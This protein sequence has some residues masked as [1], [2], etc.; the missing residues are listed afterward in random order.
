MQ[1]TGDGRTLRERMSGQQWRNGERGGSLVEFAMVL[2]LMLSVVF[3]I[4]DFGR[5]FQAWIMLT[6]SAREG[7]RVA[8]T[9]ATTSAICSRVQATS[10]L[11]GA[12]CTVSNPGGVSGTSVIVT[13]QYTIRFI[14]PIGSLVSMLGAGRLA[15][16]Y[17]LTS[18]ADMRLE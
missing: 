14:T 7:A 9:G 15:S 12:T 1:T 16:S 11:S 17:T 8:A 2:P 6:N 13:S 18:T 5:T 3:G 4:V 10:G